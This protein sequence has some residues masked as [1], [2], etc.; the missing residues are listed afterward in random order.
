MAVP[1]KGIKEEQE[2]ARRAAAGSAAAADVLAAVQP[3]HFRCT[4]MRSAI[5]L[6]EPRSLLTGP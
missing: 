2:A 5:G 3:A 1:S 6:K 4:T